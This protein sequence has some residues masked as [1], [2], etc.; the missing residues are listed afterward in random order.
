VEINALSLFDN[1]TIHVFG[2]VKDYAKDPHLTPEVKSAFESI[3]FLGAN[4]SKR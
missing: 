2:Q 4:R 3:E 1:F